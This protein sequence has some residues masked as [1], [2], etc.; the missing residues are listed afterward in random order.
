MN[1]VFGLFLLNVFGTGIEGKSCHIDLNGY[2]RLEQVVNTSQG[3]QRLIA[4]IGRESWDDPYK[5]RKI[6]DKVKTEI[7]HQNSERWEDYGC[8]GTMGVQRRF[9]IFNISSEGQRLLGGRNQVLIF[10]PIEPINSEFLRHHEDYSC[11]PL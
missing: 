4:N 5:F 6:C 9:I 7:G 8:D 1:E 2:V 3:P 10:T 11:D